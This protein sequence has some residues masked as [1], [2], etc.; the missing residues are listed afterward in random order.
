MNTKFYLLIIG[1]KMLKRMASLLNLSTCSLVRC[2]IFT[3][4]SVLK[5]ES[6]IVEAAVEVLLPLDCHGVR[7]DGEGLHH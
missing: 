7:V 2:V 4:W 1:T 6:D 5:F 3:L